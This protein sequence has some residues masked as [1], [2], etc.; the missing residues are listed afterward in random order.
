MTDERDLTRDAQAEQHGIQQWV[1][2]AYQTIYHAGLAILRGFGLP[3]DEAPRAFVTASVMFAEDI[4][5]NP[6]IPA[7]VKE[8]VFG[9]AESAL[10]DALANVQT[11]RAQWA[12]ALAEEADQDRGGDGPGDLGDPVIDEEADAMPS[13]PRTGPRSIDGPAPKNDD[14]PTTH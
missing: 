11:M 7:H 10:T 2:Q 3:G 13:T 6:G 4:A 9:D 5:N 12:A 1:V 14:E 8:R